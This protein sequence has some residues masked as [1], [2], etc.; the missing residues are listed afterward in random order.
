MALISA[1][2]SPPGFLTAPAISLMRIKAIRRTIHRE[3]S[4]LRFLTLSIIVASYVPTAYAE[5]NSKVAAAKA[6]A[7]EVAQA[8]FASD[9]S[10]VVDL[11]Y[12]NLVKIMGGRDKMIAKMKAEMDQNKKEGITLTGFT[13]VAPSKIFTNGQNDFAIL[14]TTFEATASG[15]TVIAKSYL[16]G[17]SADAGRTWGF[18]EGNGLHDPAVRAKVLP[19]LPDGLELPKKEEPEII[20]DADPES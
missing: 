1:G 9:Y 3:Y 18:I 14:P 5:D 11:T 13:V 4:M 7:D 10:T 17:I 15:V 8:V 16:L 12:P 19:E 6:K 20:R 2:V